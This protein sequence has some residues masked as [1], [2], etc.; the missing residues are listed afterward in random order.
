VNAKVRTKNVPS[1]QRAGKEAGARG[2]AALI[3][4]GAV[5]IAGSFV[6]GGVR[7]SVS[8]RAAWGELG[9][10]AR[11]QGPRPRGSARPL[12]QPGDRASDQQQAARDLLVTCAAWEPFE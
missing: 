10:R 8:L 5:S 11:M 3:A 4:G 9:G 1:G 7:G 2:S 6:F 12:S